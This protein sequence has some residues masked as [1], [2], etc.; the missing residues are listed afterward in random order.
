MTTPM[1][2]Q[3]AEK[4]FINQ[5]SKQI[6]ANAKL[7]TVAGFSLILLGMLAI[8]S[9]YLSTLAA[10]KLTSIAIVAAGITLIVY[11]FKSDHWGKG[12]LQFLMGA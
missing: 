3:D 1:T 4:R 10:T 12:A 5:L 8:L 11:C 2:L 9:P 7:A 6:K